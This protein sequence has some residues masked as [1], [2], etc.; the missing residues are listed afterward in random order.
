VGALAGDNRG[1]VAGT[2]VAALSA[3]HVHVPGEALR[4]HHGARVLKEVLA[5]A[6]VCGKVARV[7]LAAMRAHEV[8]Y[9][10][11]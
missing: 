5:A 7:S 4:R 3:E 11:V 10:A 8:E 6:A 1:C 9:G 2:H